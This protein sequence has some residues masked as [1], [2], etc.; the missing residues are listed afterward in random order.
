ITVGRMFSNTFAG[1][2][3][4]SA[5]SFIGAQLVGGTVAVAAIKVLYPRVTPAEAGNVLVP[6]DQ[7]PT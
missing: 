1:I 6:H 7:E 3:P 2:A 5:P 4:S